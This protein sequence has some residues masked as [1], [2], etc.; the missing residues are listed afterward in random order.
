MTQSTPD[1]LT[2]KINSILKLLQGSIENKDDQ[3]LVGDVL[4]NNRGRNS[5]YKRRDDIDKNIEFRKATEQGR[6]KA[7]WMAVSTLIGLLVKVIY[8]ATV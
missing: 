7:F 3:G 1:E 5:Y 4:E 6:S 2:D 8:D